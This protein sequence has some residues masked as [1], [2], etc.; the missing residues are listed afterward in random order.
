M[1]NLE[2]FREVFREVYTSVQPSTL[3]LIWKQAINIA[4]YQRINQGSLTVHS[5]LDL[6]NL[7]IR[8]CQLIES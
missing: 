8:H 5:M 7:L 2:V 6:T 1:Y 3:S 4:R